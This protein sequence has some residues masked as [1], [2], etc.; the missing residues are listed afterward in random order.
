LSEKAGPSHASLYGLMG[1][2]TLAW[3]LNYIVSKIALRELPALMVAGVRTAMAGVLIA[4]VYLW[5]RSRR[6]RLD[7]TRRDVPMLAVLGLLGVTLNQI[8]FVVGIGRTSVAHAAVMIGLCP[9]L[10]LGMAA[11]SGLET[12][13]PGRLAGMAVALAGVIVLQIAPSTG[14]ARPTLLGDFFV[15]LA[16]LTFSGFT[17]LNKKVAKK[18][19]SVTVNTFAYVGGGLLLLPVTAWQANSVALS[20]VSVAAWASVAFM[21]AFP[22][23]LAYVLYSHVLKFAP[24]SR[25]S[26]FSYLQPVLATT[27]AIPLL[28]EQPTPSLVGGGVLVLFGVFLTERL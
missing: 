21:A 7:W 27:L 13:S 26:A 3:S 22:S 2:C 24:A 28:D 18:F 23:V 12:L 20:K 5:F 8:F 16:A 14:K 1:L 6:S 9:I 10:V 15:L 25:V 11:M 4:P 19:N 17:V